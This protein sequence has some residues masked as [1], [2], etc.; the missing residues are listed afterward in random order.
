MNKLLEIVILFK[1]SL[2]FIL[3]ASMGYFKPRRPRFIFF[4]WFWIL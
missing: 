4:T 3:N 2:L 1:E